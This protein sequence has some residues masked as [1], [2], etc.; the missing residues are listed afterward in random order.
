MDL[1]RNEVAQ[2]NQHTHQS[3][4][5]KVTQFHDILFGHENILRF[6]IETER[7]NQ[8]EIGRAKFD[9]IHPTTMDTL[10]ET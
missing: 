7:K 10:K 2:S 3:R 6:D 9:E 1:K 5:A 8:R 4:K